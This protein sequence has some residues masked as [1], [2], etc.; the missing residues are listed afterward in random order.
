MHLTTKFAVGVVCL[1]VKLNSVTSFTQTEFSLKIMQFQIDWDVI[2]N[3]KR[4][5]AIYTA[6]LAC[7]M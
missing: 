5:T 3:T 7:N 2:S 4:N 6:F 1:L